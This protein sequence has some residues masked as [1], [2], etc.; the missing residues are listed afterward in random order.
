[1]KIKKREKFETLFKNKA[2]TIKRITSP[3]N[4]LSKTWVQSID[5]WVTI[6]KGNVIMKVGNKKVHLKA[7]SY[8]FLSKKVPHQF[9]TSKN[10]ET[11][12]LCVYFNSVLSR[13]G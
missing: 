11:V 6:L 3:R 7:G 1:M 9:K 5:E 10:F 12:W 8:L 13:W 2:V 4:F